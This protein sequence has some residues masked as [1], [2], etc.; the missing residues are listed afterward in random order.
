M[1]ILPARP[2][3]TDNPVT[4]PV[5]AVGVTHSS[6]MNTTFAPVAGIMSVPGAKS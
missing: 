6:V 2:A 3:F 5:G 4:S 1:S